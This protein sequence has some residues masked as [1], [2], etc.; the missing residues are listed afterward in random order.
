MPALETTERNGT[1]LMSDKPKIGSIVW[2]DL[3]VENAD[4]IRDFYCKVVGWKPSAVDMGGYSDYVVQ[5]PD[6]EDIG[7]VCHRQGVNANVPPQWM[8]Y[9]TVGNLQESMKHCEALGGKI[10][11]GPRRMGISD[12]CIIQD[13][14]G[15]VAA[16]IATRPE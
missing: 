3:T 6:G 13:P 7:G 9:I 5:S 2:K 8:M 4:E 10:V 14:A 16:L 15:A 11:D 12:Y 1:G